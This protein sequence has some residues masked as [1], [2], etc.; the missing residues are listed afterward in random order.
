[1]IEYTSECSLIGFEITQLEEEGCDTTELADRYN[2]LQNRGAPESEFAALWTI[3]DQL[4]GSGPLEYSEPSRLPAITAALPEPRAKLGPLPED[5]SNSILGGWLGRCAGCQLGK[6]VEGWPHWA[7][8]AYL[9]PKYAFPPDDYIPLLKD[10]GVGIKLHHSAA[11]STR[12]NFEF[13]ARDDDIDYMLIALSILERHG[14]G[15]SGDD[16]ATAWL[17]GIPANMTYTAERATYRN[18]L[19]GI[20]PPDSARVRN[21]FREWIGAQIRTDVYGYVCPGDPAAAARL[22]YRDAIVSHVKNGIYGALFSAA[23]NAAAFA[24]G[25]PKTALLG[26]IDQIPAESRLQRALAMVI[27]LHDSGVGW[28]EALARVNTLVGRYHGVH[29]INNACF[30]AIGLLWGNCDFGRTIAIAVACGLDTDCNGA[31]AGSILG[32]MLGA[33]A[34]PAAWTEPLGNRVGSMVAGF[35]GSRITDLAERTHRLAQVTR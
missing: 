6:P 11:E 20:N 13:M 16:V 15:F 5:L 7:I 8:R 1:M 29:T 21:P 12:G 27:E 4:A 23:C 14:F 22:A 3:A 25:D 19:L 32:A 17:E 10:H 24:A 28:E 31:T 2:D 35:D 33:R 34:L 18:L 9:E 30:V 26:G